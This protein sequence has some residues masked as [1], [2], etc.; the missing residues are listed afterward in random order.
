MNNR[1][2][3]DVSMALPWS[4]DIF[5]DVTHDN[6]N[7]SRPNGAVWPYRLFFGAEDDPNR[8]NVYNWEK[9][10]DLA[11]LTTLWAGVYN[12]TIYLHAGKEAPPS[13]V[14]DNSDITGAI[15]GDGEGVWRNGQ[16]VLPFAPVPMDSRDQMLK[17]ESGKWRRLVWEPIGL[18][19][20][21]VSKTIWSEETGTRNI[22]RYTLWCIVEHPWVAFYTTAAMID[23]P[24]AFADG[25]PARWPYSYYQNLL[26]ECKGTDKYTTTTPNDG[27]F[28][29]GWYDAYDHFQNGY[30]LAPLPWQEEGGGEL[31]GEEDSEPYD[32]VQ[33]GQFYTLPPAYPCPRYLAT[34]R[35]YRIASALTNAYTDN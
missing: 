26:W 28:N 35:D 12:G 23:D 8:A 32:G 4:T 3:P 31:E 2:M 13:A 25:V 11:E 15:L 10:D 14:D 33:T 17:N 21:A 20:V 30:R 1:D 6:G 34:A 7:P 27:G 19:D 16:P 9:V 29:V 24:D 22:K 5:P 18:F